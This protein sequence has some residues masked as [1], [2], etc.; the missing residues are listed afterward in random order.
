[1]IVSDEIKYP[2][3]AVSSRVAHLALIDALTVA[4]SSRDSETAK[5][6]ARLTHE[7]V[8]TVR[9]NE[10]TTGKRRKKKKTI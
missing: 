9:Y 10:E 8:N 4:I 2:I 7:L 3:E 1:E 6:R 5:K